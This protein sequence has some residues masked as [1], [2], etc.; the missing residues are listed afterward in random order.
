[1]SMIEALRRN[2]ARGES[3][4]RARAWRRRGARAS[5]RGRG[6]FGV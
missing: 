5:S 3:C 4:R 2:R 6:G 1:M